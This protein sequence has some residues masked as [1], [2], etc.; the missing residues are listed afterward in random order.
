M[1]LT[2]QQIYE[3]AQN[4]SNAFSNKTQSFPAKLNFIIMKNLNQLITLAQEIEQ[5][6]L[7][8]AQKYGTLDEKN[9]SYTIPQENMAQ[10]QQEL[11]DLFEISQDIKIMMIPES[12]LT[13]ELSLSM[14]QMQAILFM[15]EEEQE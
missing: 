4:M 15:I 12:A 10:V 2:N 14:E 3:Y 8:V 5:T 6:R 13:N 1:I 11:F 9:Q 7:S